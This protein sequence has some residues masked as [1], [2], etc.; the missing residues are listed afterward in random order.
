MGQLKNAIKDNL[1]VWERSHS[2]NISSKRI[3]EVITVSPDTSTCEVFILNGEDKNTIVIANVKSSEDGTIPWMPK[4][5]DYVDMYGNKQAYTITSK[6]H[7]KSF[8]TGDIS[9]YADF[10]ADNTG[11]GCGNVG[12]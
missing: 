5:G 7:I 1:L 4:P 11:G 3:G 10:M 9:Y 12:I 6:A 8:L 2:M